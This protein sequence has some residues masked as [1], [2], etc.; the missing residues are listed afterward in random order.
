MSSISW[1]IHRALAM[2]HR[3]LMT[4][5]W[6][7]RV[8]SGEKSL[9][10]N[11]VLGSRWL[12][13]RGL[14]RWRIRVADSLARRRRRRLALAVPPEQIEAFE[15]D[16]YIVVHDFLDPEQYHSIF[17][18]VMN[19]PLPSS[20]RREGMTVTRRSSLDPSDLA[21]HPRLRALIR[22]RSLVPPLRYASSFGGEPLFQVQTLFV[23]PGSAPAPDPQ[24]DLHKDTFHA[25]AKAWLFLTPVSEADGP[26]RYVPGSHRLTPERMRWEQQRSVALSES[27][28][29]GAFRIREDE[30]ADLGLPPP[31]RFTVP[32]NTL[33]I[34]D[35]SG[36]HSRT[37]TNQLSTRIEIY[38]TLRRNP[39]NPVTGWDPASL[40]GLRGR[41]NTRLAQADRLL[42]Q[43]GLRGSSWHNAG[44]RRPQD[45]PSV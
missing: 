33:V 3:L 17:D 35:T 7:L 39:F 31:R 8:F 29:G 1:S 20:E 16:G 25:T 12:N 30:L 24:T 42:K 34:A 14:H 13:E 9:R 6:S 15:R 38:A 27:G 5:V 4:P 40:P 22:G 26:L 45:P 36:F 23:Q 43:L 10:H 11:K 18:E 19:H 28:G 2:C 41:I 37:P 32:G 21:E 44:P